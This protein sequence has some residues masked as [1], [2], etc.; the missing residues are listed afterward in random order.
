MKEQLIQIDANHPEGDQRGIIGQGQIRANNIKHKFFKKDCASSMFPS[1]RGV[2][3]LRPEGIERQK[4]IRG[5]NIDKIPLLVTGEPFQR[6]SYV[7]NVDGNARHPNPTSANRQLENYLNIRDFQNLP[8]KKINELDNLQLE[9]FYYL[10]LQ[11]NQDLELQS[12]KKK[13]PYGFTTS[14][15]TSEPIQLLPIKNLI[16][17]RRF[18]LFQKANNELQAKY[19]LAREQHA[20][21]KEI[22]FPRSGNLNSGPLG[23]I[24]SNESSLVDR[25]LPS[26]GFPEDPFINSDGYAADVASNTLDGIDS[27]SVDG[28]DSGSVQNPLLDALR[29]SKNKKKLL[30]GQEEVKEDKVSLSSPSYQ[31]IVTRISDNSLVHPSA[32]ENLPL[33]I[34]FNQQA[35]DLYQSRIPRER[36]TKPLNQSRNYHPIPTL[37]VAEHDRARKRGYHKSDNNAGA[38]LESVLRSLDQSDIDSQREH[39]A[40][41]GYIRRTPAQAI[42]HNDFVPRRPSLSRMRKAH[43]GSIRYKPS[44]LLEDLYNPRKRSLVEL[45]WDNMSFTPMHAEPYSTFPKYETPQY[46]KDISHYTNTLSKL[47]RDAFNRDERL[48]ETTA[49]LNRLKARFGVI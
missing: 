18:K 13:D 8:Q 22:Y 30:Q 7:H 14:Q 29:N 1:I 47:R 24:L 11:H 40:K 20:L 41:G 12:R 15:V 49:E 44:S 21:N 37:T 33:G 39:L 25:R 38:L 34:E 3:E 48:K 16:D 31:R 32:V 6:E 28:I 2:S 42:R 43:G 45:L 23:T 27:G 5:A 46:L 19:D 36:D 26:S 10:S 9:K 17:H 4:L 35:R